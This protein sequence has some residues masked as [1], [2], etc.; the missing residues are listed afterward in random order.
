MA[1]WSGFGGPVTPTL[2]TIA[3]LIRLSRSEN[4]EC[5][6]DLLAP[7]DHRVPHHFDAEVSN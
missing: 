4:D 5:G 3:S 7:N 1:V 2:R 6:C